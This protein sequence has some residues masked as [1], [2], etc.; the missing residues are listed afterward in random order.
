MLAHSPFRTDNW[1]RANASIVVLLVPHVAGALALTQQQCLERLKRDSEAYQHDRGIRHFFVLPNDRGPCCLDG[2]YKDVEFLNHH[3]IGNGEHG[4]LHQFGW[5][6]RAPMIPCHDPNKDVSIPPPTFHLP[7]L[8]GASLSP[9]SG[10]LTAAQE[11]AH[12]KWLLFHVAAAGAQGWHSECRSDVL[13]LWKADNESLVRSAMPYK[14]FV[15][16]MERARFCIGA[17]PSP[18]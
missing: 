13:R 18:H 15:D 2:R 1:R 9:P 12:R 11:A 16:G 14:S 7:R 6:G 4:V 17:W 8:P 5:A 10:Q 3:I